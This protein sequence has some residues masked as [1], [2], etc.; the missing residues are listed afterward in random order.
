M[1]KELTDQEILSK[2]ID[3]SDLEKSFKIYIKRSYGQKELPEN[4]IKE[5]KNI[6]FY[7]AGLYINMV[8]A[9]ADI[10]DP[11]V[12]DSAVKIMLEIPNQVDAYVCKE[13]SK[14]IKNGV[15]N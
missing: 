13:L 10:N 15:P 3:Y 1:Q 6:F 5:L 2:V 12:F 14:K 11:V 9:A 4:Q 7:T 8:N